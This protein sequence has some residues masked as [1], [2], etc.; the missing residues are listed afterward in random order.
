MVTNI[1]RD[2]QGHY[3]PGQAS[4][5]PSGRPPV[6]VSLVKLLQDRLLKNENALGIIDALID[7]CIKERDVQAIKEVLDRIDGKV[8]DRHLI[9]GVIM[10]VGNEYAQLGLEA[11]K[12]DILDRQTKYLGIGRNLLAASSEAKPEN[13]ASNEE[14]GGNLDG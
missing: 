11:N 2:L 14:M 4:P 6:K 12:Q 10:H 9:Q 5:N 3:L 1:K 7:K 13:M 8:A